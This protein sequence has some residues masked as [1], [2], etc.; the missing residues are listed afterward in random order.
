M[1]K[2]MKIVD[3]AS[4]NDAWNDFSIEKNGSGKWLFDDEETKMLFADESVISLGHKWYEH[5]DM[6][7]YKKGVDRISE[8]TFEFFKSLG[9]KE[10]S[11]QTLTDGIKEVQEKDKEVL[12]MRRT[13]NNEL[14]TLSHSTQDL[15]A[16]IESQEKAQ[17]E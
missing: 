14:L 12:D 13:L 7:M 11:F 9:Q 17:E 16:T 5:K 6:T 8:E 15:K 1:K 4:E 3:F 10:A 2:E